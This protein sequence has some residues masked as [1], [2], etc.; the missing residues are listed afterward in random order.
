MLSLFTVICEAE[1]S[2]YEAKV[3]PVELRTIRV[4]GLLSKAATNAVPVGL[5]P[6]A[7]TQVHPIEGYCLLHTRS[8]A[9][10]P[11]TRIGME[12]SPVPE[13]IP[14]SKEQPPRIK[15]VERSI[16]IDMK[17]VWSIN[18]PYVKGKAAQQFIE[19]SPRRTKPAR[20]A[21]PIRH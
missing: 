6:T 14:V 1:L 17:A 21:I 4:N 15:F 12:V 3:E 9:E 2:Q 11:Q 19:A 5:K 10:L 18:P 20:N 16:S 7:T 13:T 8:P